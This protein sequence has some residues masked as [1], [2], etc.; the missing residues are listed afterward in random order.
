M[1]YLKTVARQEFET[2]SKEALRLVKKAEYKY[3]KKTAVSD[4]VLCDSLFLTHAGLKTTS[5]IL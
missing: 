4:Y 5:K 2:W 3:A 1:A